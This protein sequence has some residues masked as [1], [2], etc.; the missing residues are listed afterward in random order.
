MS[1][2]PVHDEV[3][4]IQHY[5]IK[6]VSDLRQ[7]AGFLQVLQGRNWEVQAGTGSPY[8]IFDKKMSIW[9]NVNL[10][11]YLTI[12]FYFLEFPTWFKERFE[13]FRRSIIITCVMLIKKN[14]RN[15]VSAVS[16]S[17]DAWLERNIKGWIPDNIQM[18]C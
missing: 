18:D 7:V 3:Y 14:S 15:F 9:L 11:N 12:K 6:F 17:V 5:V 2:N 16:L 1:S 8:K 4:L 10:H 13:I